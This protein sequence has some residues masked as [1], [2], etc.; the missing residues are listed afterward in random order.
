MFKDAMLDPLEILFQEAKNM[1]EN[2]S[3]I[4]DVKL[5]K[6]SVTRKIEAMAE[7]VMKMKW[8]NKYLQCSSSKYFLRMV[9][10]RLFIEGRY[11]VSFTNKGNTRAVDIYQAIKNHITEIN[12]PLQKLVSITTMIGS[13][14]G[15]IIM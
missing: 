11:T 13:A 1:N 7:N 2:M 15:F 14:V 4:P 6:N 5:F 10:E 12:L 8:I 3:H 9:F